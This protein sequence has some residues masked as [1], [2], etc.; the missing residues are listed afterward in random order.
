MLFCSY[1]FI[2][3][4]QSF[5]SLEIITQIRISSGSS[6]GDGILS[7]ATSPGPTLS[8][9]S[10]DNE[11]RSIG[12]NS[13][14]GSGIAGPSPNRPHHLKPIVVF[15]MASVDE[16]LEGRVAPSVMEMVQVMRSSFVFCTLLYV[17]KLLG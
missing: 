6:T 2:R 1:Q 13:A 14:R 11:S 7:E 16:L 12:W 15:L 4:S 3:I 10:F 8:L 17:F 5:H 9:E